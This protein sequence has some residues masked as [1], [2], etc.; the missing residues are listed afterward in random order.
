[1]I[2]CRIRLKRDNSALDS[3]ATNLQLAKMQER[4]NALNRKIKAWTAI[5]DLY[6]PGVSVLRARADRA[7]SDDT[8]AIQAYD[9]QLRLP[10]SLPPRTTCPVKL[11]IFEFKLREAQAYE[12]L[13]ELRQHLRLRTHMYKY[14]DKNSVG[15]RANTRSQ[16]LINRV[17]KKIE[18]SSAKYN[19]A[20]QALIK[21]SSHVEDV[22]WRL[23]LLPLA[24]EDIRAFTDGEPG[25]SEGR[26]TLSWIWKVVGVSDNL[27]DSGVQEGEYIYTIYFIFDAN[28]FVSPSYRMVPKPCTG[29]AVV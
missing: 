28:T 1:M 20:R 9:F 22:G 11:R 6:M 26:R 4:K 23:K 25:Q 29:N 17:Q 19:T 8:P 2:Y 27:E 21:L 5:Q 15:Q 24:P 13:E 14:K 16:N 18:A 3:S 12:A 7:A 10:S